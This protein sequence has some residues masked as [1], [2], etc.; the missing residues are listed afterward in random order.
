VFFSPCAADPLPRIKRKALQTFVLIMATMYAGIGSAAFSPASS[1]VQET[2][3]VG[4][5]V[6]ELA[7]SMWVSERGAGCACYA[8]LHCERTAVLVLDEYRTS[9]TQ[10]CR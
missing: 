4:E 9:H 7:N 8:D 2:Y 1:S 10:L 3:N 5:V 6:G